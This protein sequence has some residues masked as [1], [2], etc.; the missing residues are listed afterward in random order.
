MKV[1]F[2]T[3]IISREC[4]SIEILLAVD[5]S[6]IAPD[7]IS[8]EAVPA[9]PAAL[10]IVSVSSHK[11]QNGGTYVAKVASTSPIADFK[12]GH[13]ATYLLNHTNTFMA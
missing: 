13:I 4:A 2:R 3:N 11:F 9:L 12:L 8:S 6:L 1:C 7:L 10:P 5:I